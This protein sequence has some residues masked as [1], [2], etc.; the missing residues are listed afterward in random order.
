MRFVPD[1]LSLF[2]CVFACNVLAHTAAAQTSQTAQPESRPTTASPQIQERIDSALTASAQG[3]YQDA[4]KQYEA[5][6]AEVSLDAPT[7]AQVSLAYAQLLESELP[8]DSGTTGTSGTSGDS[9]RL[10]KAAELYQTALQTGNPAQRQLA[11]NNLGT[12]QLRRGDYADALVTLRQLDLSSESD[13]RFVYE[14]NLGRALAL[15]GNHA[16]AL[17]L[18]MSVLKSQPA[19]APAREAATQL[20]AS[21]RL[22]QADVAAAL[23]RQLIAAG[24]AAAAIE[25]LHTLLEAHRGGPTEPLLPVL[26]RAYVGALITPAEFAKSEIPF[27]ERISST[28]LPSAYAREIT[29]AV[30]GELPVI[31]RALEAERWFPL[32]FDRHPADLSALLK[33]VADVY[34]RSGRHALAL[35]RYGAA[36]ALDPGNGEAAVYAAMLLQDRPE[37]DREQRALKLLLD[38]VFSTKAGYRAKQ[39]WPNSLRMHLV[40][41]AI[42]ER[43]EQ[44]G[45][46]TSPRTAAFQYR[47]ALD[48]EQKI[49]KENPSFGRSPGLY[50]KLGNAYLHLTPPKRD[51]A[52]SQFL[53]AA[54]VFAET[55]RAEEAEDARK[56]ADAAVAPRQ[57]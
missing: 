39:D 20:L 26:V 28:S 15:T 56:R 11:R 33:H 14:Y 22:F 9:T 16:A 23:G 35:A 21:E 38:D 8:T 41:G 44:W 7:R 45:P 1:H 17:Q 24:Q 53:N 37:L 46:E 12:L 51:L 47:L 4:V 27:L 6:L 55:G 50:V 18:Y 30:V 42:F 29:L 49:L 2:A 57:H 25:T 36:W 31:T 54:G 32:W 34:L 13:R 3:G 52:R 5:T 40:L 48:A 43:L 19:F 10:A